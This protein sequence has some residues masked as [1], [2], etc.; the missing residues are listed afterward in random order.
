MGFAQNSITIE[1]SYWNKE[2]TKQTK[3]A[4][5]GEG[6]TTEEMMKQ[7]TYSGWD[8]DTVW[9]IDENNDYP[10]LR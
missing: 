10:K 5:G 7:T 1:N 9:K 2:T 6:K 8:F 4:G 3:S